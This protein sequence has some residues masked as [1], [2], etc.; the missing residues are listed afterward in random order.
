MWKTVHSVDPFDYVTNNF[1]YICH[2]VLQNKKTILINMD[3][4]NPTA[5]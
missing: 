2:V 5:L 1:V 3:I 4:L